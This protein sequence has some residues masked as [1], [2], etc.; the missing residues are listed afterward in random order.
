MKFT[1][2]TLPTVTREPRRAVRCRGATAANRDHNSPVAGGKLPLGYVRWNRVAGSERV[3]DMAKDVP[4]R[5]PRLL[6]DNHPFGGAS[7]PE[8]TGTLTLIP[9]LAVEIGGDVRSRYNAR[10]AMGQDGSAP[11]P[12]A[13]H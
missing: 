13:R 3:L 4:R 5:W 9:S 1:A 8:T 10:L 7:F 6:N 2:V 11:V 12:A